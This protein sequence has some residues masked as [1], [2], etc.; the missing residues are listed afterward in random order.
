MI[1]SF[2]FRA[3]P[4]DRI[5]FLGNVLLSLND[6]GLRSSVAPTIGATLTF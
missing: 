6:G 2:G 4:S 5:M 1:A 3:A